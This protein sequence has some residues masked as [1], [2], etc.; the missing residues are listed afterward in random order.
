MALDLFDLLAHLGWNSDI[1]IVGI[2]MGGMLVL[3]A[4]T[5]QPKLFISSCLIATK[6]SGSGLPFIATY[7]LVTN[8]FKDPEVAIK[9]NIR[10]NFTRSWL[11]QSAKEEGFDT[12]FDKVFNVS[13]TALKLR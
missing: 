6:A 7:T 10:I 11:N 5:L 8:L 3:K 4:M 1:H 9:R 13:L 12:N 2:S